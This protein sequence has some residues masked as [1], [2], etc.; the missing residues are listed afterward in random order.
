MVTLYLMSKALYA[1]SIKLNAPVKQC[2]HPNSELHNTLNPVK[3][4]MPG[5]KGEEMNPLLEC[6]GCPE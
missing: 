5:N 1:N 6:S 2:K 4:T 3:R